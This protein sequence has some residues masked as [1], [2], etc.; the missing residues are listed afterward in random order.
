MC[1][2]CLARSIEST[3]K[4]TSLSCGLLEALL[5]P[6][7]SPRYSATLL[8]TPVPRYS[9]AF[10]AGGPLPRL[11]GGQYAAP[12]PAWLPSSNPFLR[13]APSDRY[14]AQNSLTSG[15]GRIRPALLS[16]CVVV[17]QRCISQGHS[18]HVI[19]TSASCSVVILL[20][21]VRQVRLVAHAAT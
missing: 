11:P 3:S 15:G 8:L 13:L 7:W 10:S 5:M 21:S 4:T 17:E 6:S 16:C 12:K 19:M 1:L 14:T 9:L 20:S 2:I 18:R